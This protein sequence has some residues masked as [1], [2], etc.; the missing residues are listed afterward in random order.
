MST[1]SEKTTA[2]KGKA[3]RFMFKLLGVIVIIGIA[4]LLFI[5]YANYSTGVRA[6]IVLKVSKRGAIFKTYEGQLDLMSF[7]AVKSQNQLSQTFEF[8]VYKSDSEVIRELERVAL[9]GER[10]NL[11]YEE[12]YLTLPWRGS[13]Q[14]FVTGIEV[15]EG[16]QPSTTKKG[17]LE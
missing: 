13:T 15:S 8:S 5:Y 14:Y 17:F 9:S 2:F 3:K 1:F 12:K 6:G 11:Q 4:V 7:G 16:S 10:V